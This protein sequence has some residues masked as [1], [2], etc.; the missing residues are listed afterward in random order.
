LAAAVGDAAPVQNPGVPVNQHA[1]NHLKLLAF[2]LCHQA[3]VSRAVQVPDITLD[4]IRSVRELREFELTHKTP[5]GELPIRNAKDWSKTMESIEE[6]LRSY[7]GKRKIPLAYVI[8]KDVGI[9]VGADPST[10]YP[11]KHNEMI[12]RA[13][14]RAISEGGVL[15][16]DPPI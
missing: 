5:T 4:A 6:Y 16:P 9:P 2:Y 8:R 3:R 13:P 14:H 10:N 12:A 11:T 7:L 1:E 15:I